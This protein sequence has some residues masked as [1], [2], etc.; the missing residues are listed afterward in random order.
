MKKKTN[1]RVK[2]AFLQA[3]SF[4]ASFAPLAVIMG[5]NWSH[6]TATAAATTSLTVGGVLAMVVMGLKTLGKLPQK[7]KRVITYGIA[8]ALVWLLE[9]LIMDLKLILGAAF[10][11]EVLDTV[12]MQPAIT[13]AKKQVDASISAEITTEK[14]GQILAPKADD[15][16]IGRT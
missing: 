2:L 16:N 4:V 9:P 6:Y 3:G 7:P 13:Y 12:A 11:G 10:A 5:L 1:P 8:F 14:L 15:K